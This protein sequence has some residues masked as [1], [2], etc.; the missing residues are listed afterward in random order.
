LLRLPGRA[1]SRLWDAATGVNSR[2]L[3]P[4]DLD[5]FFHVANSCFEDCGIEVRRNY[6][7]SGMPIVGKPRF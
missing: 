6:E 7:D 5:N 1:L 3:D 4:K 2:T